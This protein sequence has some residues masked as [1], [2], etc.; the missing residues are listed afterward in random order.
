MTQ[1]TTIK[2]RIAA[3]AKDPMEL[4]AIGDT[5]FVLGFRLAGIRAIE[6]EGD[7]YAA[8]VE[9]FLAH[10]TLKILIVKDTDLNGLWPA[11]RQKILSTP[12]PIVIPLGKEGKAQLQARMKSVVGVDV[13]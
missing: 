8:C 1:V 4:A 3:L 2:E 9:S 6:A 12:H 10:P 11:L 13:L 7:D 5:S